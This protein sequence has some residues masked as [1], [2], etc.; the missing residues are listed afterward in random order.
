[1]KNFVNALLVIYFLFLTWLILFKLSLSIST[2]QNFATWHGGLNLIPFNGTGD[3][4]EMIA[5]VL[6]FVP[7]GGLL[8]AAGCK[9]RFAQL[10]LAVLLTSLAYEGLQ[11]VLSIGAA[12]VTDVICNTFGGL[13]GLGI[14]LF[15]RKVFGEKVMSVLAIILTII[16]CLGMI[17]MSVFINR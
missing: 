9:R 11:Y 16:T 12:D 13:L 7:Y 6:V 2:F 4:T 17:V 5:N 3:R 15:F 14:F 10:L 1:M 8:A